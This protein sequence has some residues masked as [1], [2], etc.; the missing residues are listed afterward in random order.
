MNKKDNKIILCCLVVTL[1]FF[2]TKVYAL[3]NRNLT[4]FAESNMALALTKIVRIYSQKSNSIITINFNNSYDSLS[5]IESGEP[6]DIFISAHPIW[7]ASLRQKGLIDVYNISHIA[8]DQLALVTLKSNP[9]IPPEILRGKLSVEKA[10][11]ILDELG[12]DVLFDSE[13]NSSGIFVKNFLDKLGLHN[14]KLFPKLNEDKSP[15]L[16]DIRNNSESY[17]LLF[18]SQIKNKS[19]FRVLAKKQDSRIF[20][21]ALIVAGNNME[22]AREFSLFLKSDIAKKIFQDN[23]FIVE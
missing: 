20:Y 15:L 6:A 1:F 12:K 21:Q 18:A 7:I 3:E 10:L 9:K 2:T 16:L 23:G 5:E 11:K 14:L 17:A 4:V 13:A 22:V 19:D 8:N